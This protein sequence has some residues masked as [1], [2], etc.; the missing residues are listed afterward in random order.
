M[1]PRLPELEPGGEGPLPWEESSFRRGRPGGMTPTEPVNLRLDSVIW[2][3]AKKRSVM[4]P[5]QNGLV[6]RVEERAQ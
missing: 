3:R 2:K 6:N 4:W 5:I 1:R